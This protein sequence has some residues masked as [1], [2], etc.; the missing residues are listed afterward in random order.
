MLEKL[1]QLSKETVVYGISTVVGRF[2][3]FILIPFY[4][5]IFIPVDMG[6]VSNLYSYIGIF[7]I[8]FLYGMDSAYLKLGSLKE[9]GDSKKAFSSTLILLLITSAL[10]VS[11][12]S[13]LTPQ[14]SNFLGGEQYSGKYGELLSYSANILLLDALCVVPFI[15]LRLENKALKFS[16]IRVANI[17]INIGLNLTLILGFGMGIEAVFISNL[18]ASAF[19]FVVLLPEIVK[20]FQLDFDTEII[21]RALKFGLP[22]LPAGLAAMFMQVIDKPILEKLAGLQVLGV[23][24]ANYKLGIFMMLY[25]NMFQFAWQPF[26]L[27]TANEPDAKK[28]FSKVFTYFTLAGSFIFVL[29][30]FTI[31]EIV[32]FKVAGYSILGEKYHSGIEI[33]PVI[34]LGY[35]FY[36]LYVNLNAGF[37][38]KEKSLPVPLYLSLGAILNVASNFILIPFLGMMG[39]ALSTLISYIFLAMIFYFKVQKFYKVDYENEKIV[40]ILGMSFLYIIIFYLLYAIEPPFF[41]NIS[42]ILVF[43]VILYLLKVI[44]KN[45]LL[46]VK[47]MIIS[48]FRKSNAK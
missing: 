38:I 47:N 26:F 32:N 48:K 40:K 44:T 29:L 3:N 31:K 33:I 5:N 39:A 42:L 14:I 25:V 11:L 9:N 34:L 13:V 12:I 8:V 18:V 10:F 7:N 45:E 1:K 43:P 2:L 46:T 16:L 21:L 23:Y 37:Y 24:H 22:F 19:S 30:T 35:L 20:K 15:S 4:S 36:G 41:V 17:L 27:K 6:I 28:V